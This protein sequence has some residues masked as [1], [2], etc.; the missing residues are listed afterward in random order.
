M[1]HLEE[2][3]VS[4]Y[5]ENIEKVERL[6]IPSI[7]PT[8]NEC[9][10]GLYSDL[11]Q[12]ALMKVRSLKLQEFL[13]AKQR[14]DEVETEVRLRLWHRSMKE[15]GDDL[16]ARIERQRL[17]AEAL[18]V[19][20]KDEGGVVRGAPRDSSFKTKRTSQVQARLTAANKPID[21]SAILEMLASMG[22][23]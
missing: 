22:E 6:S 4:K 3:Q 20:R 23:D 7:I 18:G 19:F 21:E 15:K 10:S 16:Q 12:D 14:L 2:V 5:V 1:A 17:E 11:P 9:P 13:E 8:T